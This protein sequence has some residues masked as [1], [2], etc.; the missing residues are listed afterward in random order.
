MKKH[1]LRLLLTLCLAN[2]LSP[3]PGRRA[4]GDR[5]PALV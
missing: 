4:G 5:K 1:G 2:R 3:W